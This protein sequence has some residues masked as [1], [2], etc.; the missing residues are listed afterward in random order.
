[1][2]FL[3]NKYTRWYFNIVNNARIFSRNGYV[4]RHHIIPKSLG[5]TNDAQNI[6][7]LSAREHFI[8]HRLLARMTVGDAKKKMQ[9]AAWILSCSKKRGLMKISSRTYVKLK[10]DLSHAVSLTMKGKP[11][12]P[13]SVAK[14]AESQ[15]GKVLSDEHKQKL[16]QATK[17]RIRSK[18]EI[19][20]SSAGL[21]QYHASKTEIFVCDHCGI[22]TKSKTNHLR[23]HGDNCATIKPRD[24]PKPWEALGMSRNTWYVHKRQG[25]LA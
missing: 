11:K 9:F 12:S 16:S 25:K 8:C 17:G 18:A 3:S 24:N 4:E 6:V 13:E 10:E 21:K 7:A 14:M 19:E 5:G 2:Q 1:M 20:A 23:W 15:R 22:E